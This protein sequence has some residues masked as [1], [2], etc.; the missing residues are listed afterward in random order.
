MIIKPEHMDK[1]TTDKRS[2]VKMMAKL[3]LRYNRGFET[4]FV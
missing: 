1:Q 4:R 2:Y 3:N